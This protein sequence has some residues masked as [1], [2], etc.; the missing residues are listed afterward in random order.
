MS[1]VPTCA[2]KPPSMNAMKCTH[3]SV[4]TASRKPGPSFHYVCC[5]L[6]GDRVQQ[7]SLLVPSPGR[8]GDFHFCQSLGKTHLFLP[9]TH[10]RAAMHHTNPP[11]SSTRWY[12]KCPIPQQVPSLKARA[13]LLPLPSKHL[14][15]PCVR[16][17]PW[18]QHRKGSNE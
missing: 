6:V 13:V 17:N 8:H 14:Y 4:T 1:G 10:I 3:T 2:M 9:D 5:S 15:L 7:L 11:S 18:C 16:P 12:F